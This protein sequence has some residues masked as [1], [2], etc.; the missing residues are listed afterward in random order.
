MT[1][2]LQSLIREAS[3]ELGSTACQ[4]GKHQWVTEG[5]RSC[6]H[7]ITDNCGQAVYRCSVCGTYDYGEPGGPGDSDCERS[8]QH[9]LARRVAINRLRID[10]LNYVWLSTINTKSSTTFHNLLLRALRRQ[11]KPKLP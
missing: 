1:A 4:A 10:P 11:P 8:C 3:T 2:A 9:R 6:P 5:G 7:D